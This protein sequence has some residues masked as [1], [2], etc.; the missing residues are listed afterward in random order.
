MTTTTTCTLLLLLLVA[1]VCS[2][3]PVKNPL[4]NHYY[5]FSTDDL[6]ATAAKS[7]CEKQTYLGLKGYLATITS[8]AE[9]AFI[10]TQ[11]NIAYTT[12]QMFW[13]GLVSTDVK[14]YNY[15]SGPE[16]GLLA[17]STLF[18]KG[19]YFYLWS[20]GE[21]NLKANEFYVHY[22]HETGRWNNNDNSNSFK[23]LCEY[24]GLTDPFIP[25]VR[26]VGD[27]N[28]TIS[29]IIGWNL[30]TN[31]TQVITATFKNVATGN[32]F[33]CSDVSVIDATSVHFTM[34]PG[35]GVYSVSIKS[36]AAA[37]PKTTTYQYRIPDVSSIYPAFNKNERITLTGD[38]FGTANA[39][40]C[41]L[42][43]NIPTSPI[44]PLLP[45]TFNVDGLTTTTFKAAFSY[46]NRLFS[47]WN[48][49]TSFSDSYESYSVN[50]RVDGLSGHLGYVDTPAL[51]TLLTK[52]CAQ[53]LISLWT[54]LTYNNTMGSY[55]SIVGTNAGL[56][57][58]LGTVPVDANS[59]PY[60]Y[61]DLETGYYNGTFTAYDQMGTLTEYTIDPP[62]F[63]N[64]NATIFIHT[65]GG[66][67]D[68][69][70]GDSGTVLSPV[71]ITF[72][73]ATYNITRD[74]YIDTVYA[75]IPAGSGGP[76]PIQVT[77][78]GF[79]TDNQQWI[80]YNA[81]RISSITAINALG[82]QVVID[83]QDFFNDPTKVTVMFGANTC[84]NV[85]FT[86][87]HKT[88]TCTAP[89]GVGSLQVLV[90][91]DGASSA[92]VTF[93]YIEP[94]VL[95]VSQ[96]GAYG[97][98]VVVTGNTL[99]TNPSEIQFSIGSIP[100]TDVTFVSAPT[101]FTCT[102]QP[103]G[104][105]AVVPV[106]MIVNGMVD[107][108]K[109]SYN[110]LPPTLTS[111]SMIPQKTVSDVVIQGSNFGAD[112]LQ[113]SV[114]GIQCL[115]VTFTS[116]SQLICR[117]DVST[118]TQSSDKYDV[119]V[120]AS[121]FF[122]K[123]KIAEFIP[124]TCADPTCSGHGVCVL[125][126]CVCND[127][128]ET[129]A[130]NCSV[131]MCADPTCSGHGSCVN[132]ACQCDQGWES[133][134]TNCSVKM[135][136]DP[137]CSGH[138]TCVQGTCQCDDGWETPATN[139]SVKMCADPTCSG[140]GSCVNGACVCNEGW[141]TPESNCSVKMCADPTCSGHGSCVNGACVCNDGWETPESNCSVK[142]CA[143]PTCSGHGSCVQGACVC[144]QGWETPATNCSVKMCADPTCSGHGTCIQGACQCDQGW[145][146]P[147]TNCSV[148]MCPN[149]C[150]GHGSCVNGACQCT[151]EWT[152]TDCSIPV[153][154][155]PTPTPTETT[156]TPT[157]TPTPT[158]TTPTPTPSEEERK[159]K[160][161]N[162]K[163]P[164][165]VRMQTKNQDIPMK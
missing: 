158:E 110:Y 66:V 63:K 100:C 97:G 10:M 113:V 17:Y 148:K 137:T 103:G 122:V 24:G 72:R 90:I 89:A 4:N 96:V 40:S 134:A 67:A 11:Y 75:P 2:A 73:G 153:T 53:N 60:Y 35:T 141:E 9:N 150:S 70:V 56:P 102:L 87:A 123:A 64:D 38:N 76:Y 50:Q 30:L 58:N 20:A 65:E 52:I 86:V 119:E 111:C 12:D 128:W 77:V 93:T 143:D 41:V 155:E 162:W 54:S 146:T 165:I 22:N 157:P 36:S 43:S 101:Q 145:E 135:C 3:L 19:P 114:A 69:V 31:P 81:P 91:V 132:G 94:T 21:P 125:D 1:T 57:I 27:H 84:S 34:P 8:P 61:F 46:D 159:K 14:V 124:L 95:S 106:T 78:S 62:S 142:M 74:F 79:T 26:T 147:A 139:C 39:F 51:V 82:G 23:Y 28:A 152:S 131:K 16:A 5:E 149:S 117:L 42:T 164:V 115:T 18:D 161:N 163:I 13:H 118:V 68:L 48:S 127:G 80:Q 37:D 154:P 160:N 44:V 45:I 6:N 104:S 107:K 140:H 98:S 83:G 92:P 156:P 15:W 55:T 32:T 116:P 71:H 33:V 144:D 120:N 126:T 49:L 7:Y 151:E 138:G 99:T 108:S 130:S 121:G 47:C 88:F 112:N 25:P 133:P 85:Q 105:P 109:L 136:D 29:N 129:P 59:Y